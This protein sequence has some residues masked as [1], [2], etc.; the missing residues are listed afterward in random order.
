LYARIKNG[1]LEKGI[2][3]QFEKLLIW[4]YFGEKMYSAVGQTGWS[5]DQA[6]HMWNL[7]L[8]PAGLQFNKSTD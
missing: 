2:L 4:Q 6:P 5:Q 3:H 1:I 7:I 8:V